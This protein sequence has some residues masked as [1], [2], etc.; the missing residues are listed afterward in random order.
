VAAEEGRAAES[1]GAGGLA[2]GRAGLG[3]GRHRGRGVGS[4]TEVGDKAKWGGG[5]RGF[6]STFF[7]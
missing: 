1:D 6:H 4:G 5:K 2:R 7:S 3:R